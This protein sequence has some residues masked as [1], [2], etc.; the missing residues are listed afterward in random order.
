MCARSVIK[1]ACEI[2]YFGLGLRYLNRL[3]GLCDTGDIL[4]I[5]GFRVPLLLCAFR[6]YG[7]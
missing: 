1:L 4:N 6:L 2:Q 5:S 7:G 3:R